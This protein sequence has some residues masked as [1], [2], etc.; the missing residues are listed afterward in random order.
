MAAEKTRKSAEDF[1]LNEAVNVL[2]DEMAVRTTD[3][4]LAARA[5]PD[6]VREPE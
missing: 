1:V 4:A 2:G 5:K 6:S 3:G